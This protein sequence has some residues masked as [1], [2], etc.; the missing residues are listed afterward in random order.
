MEEIFSCKTL[1]NLGSGADCGL[2]ILLELLESV[3]PPA[4]QTSGPH[5][6]LYMTG[7][8][9]ASHPTTKPLSHFM[10]EKI[11]SL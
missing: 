5:S 8:H 1:Q 2:M 3:S 9:E 4:D 7:I 10:G 6:V 11:V